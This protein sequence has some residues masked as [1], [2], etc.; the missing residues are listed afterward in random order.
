MNIY[1]YYENY[2]YRYYSSAWREFVSLVNYKE[3]QS[4]ALSI[5][6]IL[7]LIVER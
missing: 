6:F 5:V 1:I 3:P 7:E 2:I 4:Y